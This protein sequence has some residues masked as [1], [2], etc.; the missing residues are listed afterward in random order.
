M[1]FFQVD[2]FSVP[3]RQL[4]HVAA[5]LGFAS[6]AGLMGSSDEG[7]GVPG[8]PPMQVDLGARLLSRSSSPSGALASLRAGSGGETKETKEGGGGLRG[9]GGGGGA[10]SL[11]RA[12]SSE[13]AALG[14]ICEIL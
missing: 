2:L 7:N 13:H 4:H 14:T 5:S 6:L 1:V 8:V 12:P 3:E 9:G 10:P 11:G